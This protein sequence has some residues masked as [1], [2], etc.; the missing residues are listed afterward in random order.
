MQYYYTKRPVHYLT[1]LYHEI[2]L[3]THYRVVSLDDDVKDS[4]SIKQEVTYLSHFSAVFNSRN[5]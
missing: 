1:T 5:S 3:A 2:M 4:A